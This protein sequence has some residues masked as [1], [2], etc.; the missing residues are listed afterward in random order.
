M[1]KALWI[2]GLLFFMYA[3]IMQYND[4]DPLHWIAL[5]GI[6]AVANVGALMHRLSPLWIALGTVPHII[7][8]LM[9][10]PNLLRT[11]A[12]AFETMGM[13]NNLDE[14]VR[15]AWGTV[16]CIAWMAGLFFYARHLAARKTPEATA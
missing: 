7:Y 16:I 11:S 4:P 13:R 9:L 14:L 3:A 10:S 2:F 12:Q 8:G 6:V 5:Y 15:E 1:L